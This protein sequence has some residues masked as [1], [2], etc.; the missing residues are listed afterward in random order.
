MD[1]SPAHDSLLRVFMTYYASDVY[2]DI[3]PQS[4]TPFTRQGFTVVEW[5]GSE[6]KKP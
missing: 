4:F 1:I 2:V 3:A 5:G 6:I